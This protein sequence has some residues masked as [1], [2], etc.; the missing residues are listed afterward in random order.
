MN[1]KTINLNEE[2]YFIHEFKPNHFHRLTSMRLVKQNSQRRWL[3]DISNYTHIMGLDFQEEPTNETLEIKCFKDE[4]ID[5]YVKAIQALREFAQDRF[6]DYVSYHKV[7]GKNP[8]EGDLVKLV[9]SKK[10]SN[11]YEIRPRLF[12]GDSERE[13]ILPKDL[14]SDDVPR[15]VP[16][17]ST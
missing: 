12:V 11:T 1:K 4:D 8:Y 9:S 14:N 2:P 17:L 6:Y 5:R 13:L 16:S 3:L 15:T 10:T 7:G